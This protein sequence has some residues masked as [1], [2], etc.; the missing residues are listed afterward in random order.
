[1]CGYN[2]EYEACEDSSDAEYKWER[3]YGSTNVE[4][5]DPNGG[6][7]QY[8]D[9]VCEDCM[10]NISYCEFCDIQTSSENGYVCDDFVCNGCVA[11]LHET[12]HDEDPDMFDGV[13]CT[14]CGFEVEVP[15]LDL[16]DKKP[17]VTL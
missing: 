7:N 3:D 1:M 13:E 9:H 15:E 17:L 16:Y 14:N 12:W 8:F 4:L 11:D 6:Y 2:T 5:Q 10:D